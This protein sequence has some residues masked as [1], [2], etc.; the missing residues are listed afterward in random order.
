MEINDKGGEVVQRYEIIL[1]KHGFGYGHG[2]RRS[3]IEEW[4]RMK[5][6]W[7]KEAHK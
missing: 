2:Q 7:T 6:S 4:R 1:G 3:N 5:N